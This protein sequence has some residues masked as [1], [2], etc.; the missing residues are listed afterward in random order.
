MAMIVRVNLLFFLLIIALSVDAQEA[1]SPTIKPNTVFKAGEDLSFQ[2][3]YGFLLGGVANISLTGEKYNNKEVLHARAIAQTTGLAE[4]IFG[5]KDIYESWFDKNSNLSYKQIRNISEGRYRK[6]NEVTY[7]RENNTV[8]SKL[9]GIHHVPENILDLSTTLYYIR[10]ID[11]ARMKEGDMIFVN[12]YFDDEIFPFYMRYNGKEIIRTQFGKIN[13][14]KISPVV[15]VGRMFKS[16]DD[17]NIW[18]TDD[19][20]SLPVLVK[21][22]IR[23]VGS[24]LLKLTSYENISYPLIIQ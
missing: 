4:I 22:N 17:L 8:N 6:Y 5:V 24:V 10:R 18:L 14:L 12:M 9:S 2:I 1:F 15:E 11:F 13:C 7:N 19:A 21:A 3:R 23:H 20:N 16:P